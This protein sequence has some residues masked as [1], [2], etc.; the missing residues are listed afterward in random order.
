[1]QRLILRFG[2]INASADTAAGFGHE[3]SAHRRQTGSYPETGWGENA[4]DLLEA[5]FWPG[6]ISS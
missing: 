1:L 2:L 6:M 4:G 5:D 3:C